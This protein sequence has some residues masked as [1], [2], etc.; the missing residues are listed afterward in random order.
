MAK[1]SASFVILILLVVTIM[2]GY[3]VEGA[4]RGN[5][6]KNDGDVFKNVKTFGCILFWKGCFFFHIPSDCS[7]YNQYCTLQGINAPPQGMNASPPQ[8]QILP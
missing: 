3:N 1:I 7:M 5:K 8:A 4:G 2:N 6:L